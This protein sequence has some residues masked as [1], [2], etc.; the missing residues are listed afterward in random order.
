MS[1]DFYLSDPA[2]AGGPIGPAA[3]LIRRDGR[4]IE[5]SREEWKASHPPEFEPITLTRDPSIVFWA[6]ITH[7]L[8][9][10]AT[11]AL[12]Y[13]YLW[14]PAANGIE[15]AEQLIEPLERGLAALEIDPPFFKK[16]NPESGW[17][18]YQALVDFVAEV[19]GACRKFPNARVEV[20]R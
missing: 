18:D 13:E 7:N 9:G 11:A 17:G 4:V 14:N 12:V 20:S 8:G 6:N 3:I 19:L 1:L 15:R 2:L 16:L 5:I 10:M